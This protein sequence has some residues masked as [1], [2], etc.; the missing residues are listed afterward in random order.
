MTDRDVDADVAV[1]G[2]GPVGQALAILLA[3]SGHRVTVLERRPEPYRLPRAVHFD[4][5][6]ARAFAGMGIGPE[7]ARITETADAY[8]WRN[9]DGATLLHFDW[10]GLGPGAWPTANMFGQ[11]ELEAVLAERAAALG[12]T[13]R[14]GCQVVGIS[15]EHAPDGDA[16]RGHVRLTLQSAGLPD[17]PA[18][19]TLTARYVVGCDGANSFVRDHLGGT[20]TD[21]G[22]QYDWLIVD[23][24]PHEPRP[25]HPTNLQLCD[26]ARPTTMVSGGP[27]RRRWEFM[28]LPHE[29]TADLDTPEAAWRLLAPWDVTPDTATLE[30]H[31]VYTFAARWAE[32]WRSGRVLIAG[33]AAHLMPPFA[34][35][36][37]CSGIRDAA[38]LAWKLD[39]VLTGRAAEALLDTYTSERAAHVRNAI[40]ISV[41]LGN[42]ICLADPAAAAL[43]DEYL[44]KAGGDP[45]VALPPI[46]PAVLGPGV[47][48]TDA[49]GIPIGTAGQRTEQARVTDATGRTDRLDQITGPGFVVATTT[50]LDLTPETTALLTTLGAH[51]VHITEPGHLAPPAPDGCPVR[52]VTDTDGFYLPHMRA[53][54]HEIAVVR[55]DHYL[56]G[57]AA[58]AAE[59]PALLH[60]LAAALHL[61]DPAPA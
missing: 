59:L 38:N 6:I 21:L 12:V 60:A 7:L 57:T 23:V 56:F 35:Q 50:G 9:A 55:P 3:Q 48:H 15:E 13:V 37:M 27:G 29:T 46:P 45:E 17:G 44:L 11:P 42:V 53:N 41:E 19:G 54:G 1:V 47:L 34:G 5:E 39:L 40:A 28:R 10:G 33:D 52:V 36:G 2:A 58:T 30:R 51:I 4:D 61:R 18:P 43:R 20:V 14:R 25:W 32:C 31:T 8:D 22:F 24:V 26:P 16:D 49:D